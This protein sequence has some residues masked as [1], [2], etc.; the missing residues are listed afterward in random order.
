M[1]ANK[2]I[3]SAILCFIFCLGTAGSVFGIGMVTEP[4]VV[5]NILRGGEIMK[6][7]TVLNPEENEVFYSFGSEG[8]IEGWVTFFET[9]NLKE[10]IV[11]STI[12]AKSYYDVTAKI[13]VPEGT[14]NGKYLGEIFVKKEAKDEERQGESSVSVAHRISR[15]VSIT[16]T[17]QEVI[18]IGTTMIPETYDLGQG[19]PLKIKII[20]ENTGNIV[21]EPGLHLKITNIKEEKVV[22]NAI[23]PYFEEEEPIR[24]GERRT[25][26]VFE[27]QTVGQPEGRYLA[28]V[29]TLVNNEN[30]ADNSFRFNIGDV[31][32]S[33]DGEENSYLTDNKVLGAVAFVGGGNLTI[34]WFVIGG[35]LLVLALVL[36]K[37]KRL[38]GQKGL[39]TQSD[40]EL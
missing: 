21:L 28:E 33:L 39:D 32:Y 37:R 22:F 8:G 31:V 5:D 23:F 35:I 24:P 3:F 4:I 6:T 38:I 26:P 36:A 10:E 16:V 19:Q 25:M 17:D 40:K 18:G 1:K 2:K 11:K 27:W 12:P 9:D 30:F 34:G 15:E 20:Y 13:K 29:I 7:I 14:P